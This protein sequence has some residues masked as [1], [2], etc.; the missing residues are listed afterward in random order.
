MVKMIKLSLIGAL[1]LVGGTS[2]LNNGKSPSEV[3]YD[4]PKPSLQPNIVKIDT[5]SEANLKKEI[6][7]LN[8][9]HSDIVFNQ[10]RLETGNF[11]SKVFKNY[12]NLFGFVGKNG[13]IKYS[14]W[15]QSVKA[16]KDFQA[17]YYKSGDYYV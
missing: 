4:L 5:F 16:Y 12:H 7:D 13:Y 11:K 8:I 10:A 14:D 9:L 6:N 1:L 2:C 3:K 17:K 15:K